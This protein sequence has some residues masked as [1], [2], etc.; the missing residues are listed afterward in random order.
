MSYI[1][2]GG[3]AVRHQPNT[4]VSL[5]EAIT[6]VSRTIEDLTWT[7]L[8]TDTR[9]IGVDD[10]WVKRKD[11]LA[12]FRIYRRRSPLA[13][14]AFNLL[15]NYVLGQGVTIRPNNKALVAKIVDEFWD[16]PVNQATF[17]SHESMIQALDS[18]YTDGDLFLV[19]FPDR[20]LGTVQLGWIDSWRVQDVITD[21]EN[22]R[23]PMWY[24]VRKS[25]GSYDFKQGTYQAETDA[26]FVYY[27]DYRNDPESPTYVASD[28]ASQPPRGLVVSGALIYHVAINKRGKFGESELAAAA[29]WLKAHKDFMEDRATLSRAAAQI[30]WRKKRKGPASDIANQVQRLQSSL[31]ENLARWETNPTSASGS[32]LVEN[33]GSTME[34][35]KTDTGAGNA[36]NDER[37]IRMMVGSSVGVMNHYFGDEGSAN[38]ATATAM[39]L[40]MLKMYE[41]WQKL[42]GDTLKNLLRYVL[43]IAE[44]AGRVGPEDLSNKYKKPAPSDTL[45]KL[46]SVPTVE[47]LYDAL[48]RYDEKIS[49]ATPMAV[50]TTTQPKAVKDEEWD[51]TNAVDWY[52][53]VDFPPIVQREISGYIAALKNVFSMMPVMNIESQKLVVSMALTVLG[54]NDIDEVMAKLFSGDFSNAAFAVIPI[55]Q[56]SALSPGSMT[57]GGG[58][59]PGQSGNS[60][61]Q[62]GVPKQPA[63]VNL[64]VGKLQPPTDR[65]QNDA[66]SK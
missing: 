15:K 6:D 30:A 16:D 31:V 54:V 2:S 18:I 61:A 35:V 26:D 48:L 5:R 60:G 28:D 37:L 58:S 64:P 55:Q 38:L 53:D 17:T 57:V 46:G 10:D 45:T 22:W 11:L 62:P 47:A 32:T 65:P 44:E 13:K 25:K 20:V 14:Q 41:G 27:R 49:E 23:L 51:I 50:V 59:V 4:L 56:T 29:D 40:P 19:L 9:T 12:R 7:N 42:L 39:E 24:K 1:V 33:D 8:S 66:G 21:E 52:I 34:W 36:I 63:N 3:Q 43:A